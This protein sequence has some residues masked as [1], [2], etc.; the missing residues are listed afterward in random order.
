MKKI[1]L[2]LATAIPVSTLMAQTWTED[3]VFVTGYAKKIFYS[4]ENGQVS[5][6]PTNNYDLEISTSTMTSSIRLNNGGPTG[7]TTRLY[8]VA[9]DTTAWAGTLDTTG[10]GQGTS[11]IF[12]RCLDSDSSWFQ[13]AFEFG[14][15]GHPD[16]GWGTYSMVTHNLVGKKIFLI[17]THTGAWK[18]IWIRQLQS[19]AGIYKV[20]M[21]DLDGSNE[22]NFDMNRS[23]Y[24]NK[25]FVYF[26]LDTKTAIDAE[27]AKG[28]F[29]LIFGRYVEANPSSPN[30]EMAVTGVLMND[31]VKA[32]RAAGVEVENADYT[33][34]T[35]ISDASTVGDAWKKLN[36]STFQWGVLDSLSY[37]IQDRNGSL[38]QLAFTKFG[39]TT[40]G[41]N[42]FKKRQLTYA[43]TDL[44]PTIPALAVFPNPAIEN[45]NL[46]FTTTE[47]SNMS[48]Q[49]IDMAGRVVMAQNHASNAG[50][51]QINLNLSTISQS[52]MYFVRMTDGKTLRTEKIMIQR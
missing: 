25:N 45:V 30:Y 13:S 20:R 23:G 28:S 47:N 9:G 4:L 2:I 16:Y 10:L 24:S 33:N 39:G 41:L 37:F 11:S 18:K 6:T 7:V 31:S 19:M 50:I 15:A 3:S 26:N 43:S 22:E 17:K 35:L 1:I 14:S 29:D 40:N 34:Y 51:N 27:P 52:G 42:K 32:A 5:E 12:T 21:A 44:Y 48:I 8:K 38:W 36:Y 49:L 46:V